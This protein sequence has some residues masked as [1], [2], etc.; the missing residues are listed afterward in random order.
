VTHRGA[1]EAEAAL[2][3]RVDHPAAARDVLLIIGDVLV[4]SLPPG[5]HHR[6]GPVARTQR[7]GSTEELLA[8]GGAANL[9]GGANLQTTQR[10]YTLT[11][12]RGGA[13]RRAFRESRGVRD[14]PNPNPLKV[15]RM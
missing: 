13:A 1:A 11:S 4:H 2:E 6:L 3:L 9:A 5:H 10:R 8:G 15:R 12:R 14:I 7:L